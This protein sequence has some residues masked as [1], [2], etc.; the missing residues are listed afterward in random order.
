MR[1][2]VVASVV[3]A[4][5]AVVAVAAGAVALLRGTGDD[6]GGGA[7]NGAATGAQGVAAGEASI[8]AGAGATT[9]VPGAGQ[10]P[11]CPGGEVGGV[12]LPCLG[13]ASSS[14]SPDNAAVT[15]VSLWAWWCEPCRKELPI[16]DDYARAHPEVQVVGVHADADEARGVAL[17]N[18]L[19]VGLPSYQDSSGAFAGQ[20]GLPGVVPILLVFRG[21][22]RIGMFP[23]AFRSQA[24]IADAVAGVL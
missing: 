22:E 2:S 12:V 13:G 15:V 6:A 8:S 19:G 16:I 21:D 11:D 1:R 5:L 18:D 23:R 9:Q 17:L 4:V 14:N 7:G 24:E 10:R 3:A 20:L